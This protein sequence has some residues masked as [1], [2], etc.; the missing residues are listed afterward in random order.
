[1]FRRNDFDHLVHSVKS[2]WSRGDVGYPLSS[3]VGPRYRECDSVR[4]RAAQHIQET[5]VRCVQGNLDPQFLV[6]G[7]S[8][9]AAEA[10]RILRTLSGVRSFST[11]D[12]A[13]QPDLP[14]LDR[15]VGRCRYRP[16][17]SHCA[18]P[19][20]RAPAHRPCIRSLQEICHRSVVEL[21]APSVR[22][23][24]DTHWLSV[25]LIPLRGNPH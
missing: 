15:H 17:R 3:S 22:R 11:L 8:Q 4:A 25:K 23:I 19:P 2:T 20:P 9:L 13:S 24:G 18:L 10:S 1:M 7:G 16:A 6:I 14:R 21:D 12:T 5:G